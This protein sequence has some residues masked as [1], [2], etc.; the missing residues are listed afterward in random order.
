MKY[1]KGKKTVLTNLIYNA[2]SVNNGREFELILWRELDTED[3]IKAKYYK[4]DYVNIDSLDKQI[5]NLVKKGYDKIELC[6]PDEVYEFE[7]YLLYEK[8][9]LNQ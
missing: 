9:K 6:Y 4:G 1:L 7:H 5:S 2:Q 8:N 3:I